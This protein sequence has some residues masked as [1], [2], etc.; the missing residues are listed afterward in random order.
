M[1][2][3][4]EYLAGS[5]HASFAARLE[6][7][8]G[9]LSEILHEKKQP[10]LRLAVRIERETNGAVPVE[11]WPQFAVLRDRQLQASSAVTPDAASPENMGATSRPNNPDPDFSQDN[12]G[13]AE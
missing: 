3:L 13:G 4:R 7:S 11:S 1:T 2:L 10:G 12:H 6:I 9:F 5:R 8:G